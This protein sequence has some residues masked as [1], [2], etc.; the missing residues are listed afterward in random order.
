MR[1]DNHEGFARYGVICQ[2]HLFIDE[3][4]DH[5]VSCHFQADEALFSLK[6]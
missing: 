5:A 1:N 2:F 3:L 6:V 4:I